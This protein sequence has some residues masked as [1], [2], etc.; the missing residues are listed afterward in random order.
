MKCPCYLEL[1]LMN[2]VPGKIKLKMNLHPIG[3]DGDIN[4]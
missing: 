2:F 3:I 4:L 1:N